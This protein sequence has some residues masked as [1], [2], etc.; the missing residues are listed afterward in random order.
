M[1]VSLSIHP[2]SDSL[3]LYGHPDPSSAYSLSGHVSISLASTSSLFERR[4]AVRLLLQSLTITFEGQTELITT[5]TGYSGMRLCSITREL[6]PS[7]P[8]E[9]SNEGQEDSEAPCFWN[10]IFNIQVPG[11]LPPSERFGDISESEEAGT[12]Y[13]LYATAKFANVF[14]PSADQ[15]WLLSTLCSSF[16]SKPRVVSADRCPIFIRRFM[17]APSMPS[18]STSLFPLASFANE[19]LANLPEE[20]P[21]SSSIPLNVLSKIQVVASVPNHIDVD[22][23]SIPLTLR[24]RARDL[25]EDVAARLRLTKFTADVEQTEKFRI[26]PSSEY[27]AQFPLPPQSEQP[28]YKSLRSCHPMGALYDLGFATDG[29]RRSVSRSFSVLSPEHSGS[30]TLSGGEHVFSESDRGDGSLSSWWSIQTEVPLGMSDEDKTKKHWGGP[31]RLRPTAQTPLFDVRHKLHL[32]LAYT[33][34]LDQNQAKPKRA[35][36]RVKFCIPLDFVRVEPQAALYT[37]PLSPASSVSSVCSLTTSLSM[38]SIPYTSTLPPY[39]QLYDCNG[40]RK[41]DY[42]TPLPLYTPSPVSP[43]FGD[44][45]DIPPAG[46]IKDA[47]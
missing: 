13:A 20:C 46:S 11:W 15:S 12:S 39:S 41:I 33:Y 42:S 3:E 45:D 18:S 29:P 23:G 43:F 14:E 28:P 4:R 25:P 17:P 31:R 26:S 44:G 5:E 19:P 37:P 2:F 47:D 36:A 22:E 7:D 1:S 30:F 9:L 16:R 38:T 8:I 6:A 32:V 34:D 21:D 27:T 24:L 40:E 10:V 35:E